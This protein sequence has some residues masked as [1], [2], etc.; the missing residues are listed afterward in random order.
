MFSIDNWRGG[1]VKISIF[2]TWR[3]DEPGG[4][5]GPDGKARRFCLSGISP[6]TGFTFLLW[7]SSLW[8]LSQRSP[9]GPG[10]RRVS[11]VAKRVNYPCGYQIFAI[12][13]RGRQFARQKHFYVRIKRYLLISKYL[14]TATTD[15]IT[16]KPMWPTQPPKLPVRQENQ[17][18]LGNL[19]K[20]YLRV[21][22]PH[23]VFPSPKP[24]WPTLHL[25]LPASQENQFCIGNERKGYLRVNLPA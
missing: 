11:I 19:R 24:M 1:V 13:G 23:A 14:P 21:N 16:S 5:W 6:L 22:L 25:Q 9:L 15:I 2:S 17:F 4:P 10:N 7:P 8:H 3:P 18:P 12:V 20:G